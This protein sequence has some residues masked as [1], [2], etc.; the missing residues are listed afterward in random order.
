[1]ALVDRADL[2]LRRLYVALF[3]DAAVGVVELDATSPFYHTE[4]AEIR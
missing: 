2:G 1:M 3:Q 4:V